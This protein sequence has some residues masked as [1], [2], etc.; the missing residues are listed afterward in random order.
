MREITFLAAPLFALVAFFVVTDFLV[1]AAFF[2][3]VVAFLTAVF[4]GAVVDLLAAAV[5]G[6]TVFAFVVVRA[7]GLAEARATTL[8]T[9]FLADSLV[10]TFALV[11]ADFPEAGFLAEGFV[12]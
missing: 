12:F 1:A 8:T 5:V 11:I 9:D 10:A 4:L 6:L 7:L 3:V 2:V